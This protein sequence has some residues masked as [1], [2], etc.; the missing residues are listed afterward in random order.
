V[1]EF[2]LDAELVSRASDLEMGKYRSATHNR[3]GN[4]GYR[5]L[6]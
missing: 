1:V 2:R 3:G 6:K 5:L 4:E